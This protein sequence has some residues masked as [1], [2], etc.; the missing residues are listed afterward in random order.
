MRINYQNRYSQSMYLVHSPQSSTVQCLPSQQHDDNASVHQFPHVHTSHIHTC[1]PPCAPCTPCLYKGTALFNQAKLL[2]SYD[3]TPLWRRHR[4][5]V[6]GVVSGR[7]C[8][9]NGQPNV[10]YACNA[11]PSEGEGECRRPNAEA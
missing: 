4:N 8:P 5:Q 3:S 2:R 11:G 10:M 7:W 1:S 9:A 6:G